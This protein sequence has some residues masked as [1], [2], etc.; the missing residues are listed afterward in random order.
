MVTF[1]S[2]GQNLF[3]ESA[4]GGEGLEIISL[5]IATKVMWHS[6]VSNLPPLD[7]RKT[8]KT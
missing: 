5:S 7:L 1:A 3:F 4:K 8:Y 2:N 6:W